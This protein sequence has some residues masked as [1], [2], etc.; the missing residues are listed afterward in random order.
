MIRWVPC[1]DGHKGSSAWSAGKQVVCYTAR[2]ETTNT[3][4]AQA[5]NGIT[6]ALCRIEIKANCM[7]MSDLVHVDGANDLQ[8]SV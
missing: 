5:G 6:S 3:A 8:Y 2:A 7:A 4:T 1:I